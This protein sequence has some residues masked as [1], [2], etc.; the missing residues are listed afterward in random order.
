MRW[1]SNQRVCWELWQGEKRKSEVG[2]NEDVHIQSKFVVGSTDHSVLTQH[3]VHTST[4]ST[5]EF[6]CVWSDSFE[7][8]LVEDG[9]DSVVLFPLSDV[10]SYLGDDTRTIWKWNG[11]W[12]LKMKWIFVH[13]DDEIT[14]VEEGEE[15]GGEV[16]PI[17]NQRVR[18]K[19]ESVLVFHLLMV[20]PTNLMNMLWRWPRHR[21]DQLLG[22][23]LIWALMNRI[24][25]SRM[26]LGAG[27]I[28]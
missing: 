26:A 19:K 22:L 7:M 3:S 28:G 9:H 8:D 15:R 17:S 16:S 4:Q 11:W 1:D 24:L 12:I 10:W 14:T 5:L 25:V 20:L 13:R 23:G 6:L 18:T 27:R 2:W 21:L